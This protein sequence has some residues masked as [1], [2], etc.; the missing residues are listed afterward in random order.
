MKAALLS[1]VIAAVMASTVSAASFNLTLLGSSEM[2]GRVV[3]NQKYDG[4]CGAEA[5]GPAGWTFCHGGLAG[6]VYYYENVLNTTDNVLSVDAG[7][8]FFGTLWWRKWKGKKIAEFYSSSIFA[9]DALREPSKYTVRPM[10]D[11]M[12][13]STADFYEG[14]STLKGIVQALKPQVVLTNWDFS[15]ETLFQ[16]VNCKDPDDGSCLDEYVIIEKAGR[17]I[18]FM[19]FAP[20]DLDEISNP[21]E[22]MF[23]KNDGDMVSLAQAMVLKIQAAHP[24]CNIIIMGSGLGPDLDKAVARKVSGIDI[25]IG[26]RQTYQ[27]LKSTGFPYHVE[28]LLGDD[29]YICA[30]GPYGSKL[31][32]LDIIFDD[33]GKVTGFGDTAGL[34][35]VDTADGFDKSVWDDVFDQFNI[36][37]TEVKGKVL[38][39]GKNFMDGGRGDPSPNPCGGEPAEGDTTCTEVGQDCSDICSPEIDIVTDK[40]SWPAENVPKCCTQKECCPKNTVWNSYGVRHSDSPSGHF[41]TNA[42]MVSCTKC[43]AAFQ[44]GGGIRADIGT[45]G[46]GEFDITLGNALEAYP[47]QN[48]VATAEVQGTTLVAFLAHS[49]SEY[50]ASEGHGK[51][52]QMAGTRVAW[53]PATSSVISVELCR[54]WSR[55]THTCEGYWLPLVGKALQEVYTIAVN[56]FIMGGGDGYDMLRQEATNVNEFGQRLDTAVADFVADHMSQWD[57]AYFDTHKED[58]SGFQQNFISKFNTTECR[59]LKAADSSPFKCPRTGLQKCIDATNGK[60]PWSI[61]NILKP[62]RSGYDYQC[63]QCSGFG[64][65]DEL[66]G[67]VCKCKSSEVDG[68]EWP[69]QYVVEKAVCGGADETTGLSFA[70]GDDCANLRT[71]AGKANSGIATIVFVI[72][73]ATALYFTLFLK[74]NARHTVIKAGQPK[75]QHMMNFGCVLCGVSRFISSMEPSFMTCNLGVALQGVGFMTIL[76]PLIFKTAIIASIFNNKSLKRQKDKRTQNFIQSI[77]LVFVEVLLMVVMIVVAPMD[78]TLMILS[79]DI[80]PHSYAIVCRAQDVDGIPQGMTWVTSA[81][82][83]NVLM[84][85][86]GV[87][88]AY[89]V[90]NVSSVFG[91][92]KWIGFVMYNL[93]IF[94]GIGVLVGFFTETDPSSQSML[95]SLM[96]LIACMGAL[97]IMF[98]PKYLLTKQFAADVAPMSLA[99]G[100]ATSATAGT[101][102]TATSQSADIYSQLKDVMGRIYE[103]EPSALRAQVDAAD[104]KASLEKLSEMLTE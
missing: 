43:D 17:K 94:G 80:S 7:N 50:M 49:V 85:I 102:A 37:E 91:E 63:T 41:V 13:V 27:S 1:G 89:Q 54:G 56:N 11:A 3:G 88:S 29:V 10:F 25:I 64:E 60:T 83:L 45:P 58:C 15:Q 104:M 67:Y 93:F 33:A 23:L 31:C 68:F 36:I 20:I 9:D 97:I 46:S 48:T 4:Q 95:L 26:T 8:N 77:L 52:H 79:E 86:W 22:N 55:V 5:D 71:R 47:Y 76:S 69:R 70:G 78:K 59:I 99:K 6:K 96:N 103:I 87:Y 12:G 74:Q 38:G 24:D 53:N 14:A 19:N 72:I 90:R 82:A 66:N 81:L 40:W 28:N 65:C 21:G 30:V 2:R 51:F 39:K 84:L 32:H 75:F 16:S 98:L 35:T 18:A 92:A 61:E 73:L 62:N 44:N 57:T 100:S 42:M 101:S 34:V